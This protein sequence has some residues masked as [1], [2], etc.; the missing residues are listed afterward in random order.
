MLGSWRDS[1]ACG[2]VAQ[3][4]AGYVS[5][6]VPVMRTVTTHSGRGFMVQARFAGDGSIYLRA[7]RRFRG[8]SFESQRPLT[9]W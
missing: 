7:I 8:I 5:V 4:S 1:A 2:A 9:V 6:D 3:R